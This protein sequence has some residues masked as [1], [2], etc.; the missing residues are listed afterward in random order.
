MFPAQVPNVRLAVARVVASLSPRHQAS[1]ADLVE[2]ATAQLREDKDVDVRSVMLA[3]A[4][5]PTTSSQPQTETETETETELSSETEP[6]IKIFIQYERYMSPYIT[7][8]ILRCPRR[9]RRPKRLNSDTIVF[10]ESSPS[11]VGSCPRKS[12]PRPTLQIRNFIFHGAFNDSVQ[13]PGN[14]VI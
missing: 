11:K 9:Q 4:P 7:H 14:D 1:C 13:E 8:I 6:V 10:R 5:A 3:T 2:A 12:R